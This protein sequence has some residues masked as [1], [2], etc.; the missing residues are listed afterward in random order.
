MK[1]LDS[2]LLKV[3]LYGL[4]LV[5]MLAIFTY[6]YGLGVFNQIAGKLKLLYNFAGLAFALWMLLSIYLSIRLMVSGEFRNIVL[7]KLT[8]IREGDEREVMLTGKATKTT[9]LTS[10][11]LLIFLFF[12][13]CFQV[14]IYRV[15]PEKAVDGKTGMVSLGFGFSLLAGAKPASME[16]TIQKTDIFSYTGLPVSSTTVILLLILWQIICYNY[17]MQR[18]ITKELERM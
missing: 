2:I 17:S 8:F 18:L 7:A 5:I 11:A 10:L 9:F 15:P 16:G 14:S 4:P 6:S 3:F 13:S 12:L 1:R